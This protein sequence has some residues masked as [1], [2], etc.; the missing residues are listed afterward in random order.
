MLRMVVMRLSPFFQKCGS[1]FG[2][3]LVSVLQIENNHYLTGGG[4]RYAHR[5]LASVLQI[6]NNHHAA[7][8]FFVF[9]NP[10]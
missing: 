8:G 6:E 7:R 9:P 1:T 4:V 3:P 10:F 5:P 2:D